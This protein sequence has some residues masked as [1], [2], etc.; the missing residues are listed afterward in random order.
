MKE[1]QNVG[2]EEA[3]AELEKIINE[4]Q[5]FLDQLQEE[6]DQTKLPRPAATRRQIGKGDHVAAFEACKRDLALLLAG[7]RPTDCHPNG[8]L[9]GMTM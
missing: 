8:K 4:N 9:Q 2:L 1:E 3:R 6:I 5:S 7:P